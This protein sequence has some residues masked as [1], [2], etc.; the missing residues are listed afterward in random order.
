MTH[1]LFYE[2]KLANPSI[3]YVETQYG[4]IYNIIEKVFNN[5]DFAF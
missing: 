1:H 5:N 3:L 4:P 2:I